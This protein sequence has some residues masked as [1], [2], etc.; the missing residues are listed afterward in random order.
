MLGSKW[1]VASSLT[2]VALSIGSTNA[3]YIGPG[4]TKTAPNIAEI[5]K[6]PVDDM[7]VVLR[8]KLI[9]KLS[10]DKYTV[11]D[12][13]GEIVV[14]IDHKRFP[15]QQVTQTARW[16]PPLTTGGHHRNRTRQS[17]VLGSN[18]PDHRH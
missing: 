17:C 5:L 13:S 1:P 8:G 18:S 9:N 12:G 3:Q 2:A 10:G 16:P 4:A 14:E 11:S 15:A 7:T 6:N